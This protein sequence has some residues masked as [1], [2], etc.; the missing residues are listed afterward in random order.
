MYIIY[1][2]DGP[3]NPQPSLGWK[4]VRIIRNGNDYTLQHADIGATT[5]TEVK[6]VR[7]ANYRFQYVH[8]GNGLVSV[9]PFKTKWDIAW[10]GFANTTNLGTGP[11]PYYFQDIILQNISG[12]QT[13]QVLTSTVT[14]AAFAEANIAALTFGTNQI[15]IGANWRSGGGPGTAPAIRTDRF[16]VIKDA[17]GNYYKLKFTSLTT[18]GERGKP[19]VEFALVKKG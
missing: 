2:G 4:K 16:Y 19:S 11:V 12:V 15:N 5:F 10:T 8:F 1:R 13:V 7:D 17:D 6:V 18:N 3:G 9:E 14:Y